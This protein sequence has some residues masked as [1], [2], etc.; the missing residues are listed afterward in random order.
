M[1]PPEIWLQIAYHI[2]PHLL[3]DLYAV[4]RQWYDMA[5]NARY[6]QISFAFLNRGMLHDLTRL[7]DPAVARRV[8]SLH[9][10][11]YFVKEILDKA[12][13]EPQPPLSPHSLRGKLSGLFRDHGHNKRLARRSRT[14]AT[15]DM[16]NPAE[17]VKS[18]V[19]VISGLTNLSHVHIAWSGLDHIHDLPVPFLAAAFRPSVLQLSLE[20][21]LEKTVDLLS[22]TSALTDLE[23]LD[24]FLRLDHQLSAIEY[25]RILVEHVAPAINRLH[26]SLQ[27]LSLRLCEPVDLAPL[28]DSL[29]HMSCL[30]NLS[31]SIPTSAPHLGDPAGFGKFLDRHRYTLSHLTLRA[32]ELSGPGLTVADEEP[33]SA[34]VNDALSFLSGPVKLRSLEASL[35]LFPVEAAAVCLGHLGRT[36]TSLTLTGRYLTYD[37][38][39]ELL[40]AVPRAR[41][42]DLRLGPVTLSPQLVDLLAERLPALRQL[43]LLVR[44]VVG[45]EGDLPVYYDRTEQHDGQIGSFFME[46]EGRRY[47]HWGLRAIEL[48]RSSFP[49]RMQYAED[50]KELFEGC[51]PSLCR[52]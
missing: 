49:Y 41:L 48:E 40:S 50:Y 24:L 15:L 37:R 35:A 9:I 13:H 38:V 5:M 23:E 44:D 10:H 51:V 21:S 47:G 4:N 6:R 30:D 12:V 7:R 8:R 17:L 11:P 31:I 27:K 29:R 42:R 36:L 19:Q 26:R 1:F 28:F 34:W 32:T 18:V 2:P 25:E 20:I 16:D 45:C 14:P 39:D 22:H 52:A 3:A 43:A 46:M 33:L